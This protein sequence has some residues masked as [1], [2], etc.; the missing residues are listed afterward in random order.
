M[1]WEKVK[2]I[3]GIIVATSAV[4]LTLGGW[5][6]TLYIDKAI[7]DALAELSFPSDATIA[8]IN[9]E[10]GIH[11]TKIEGLGDRQDFTEEQLQ[12]MARILMRRPE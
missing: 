1:N 2:E 12:D 11:A 3:G 5:L 10:I 7:D 4:L 6:V 9:G 8:E